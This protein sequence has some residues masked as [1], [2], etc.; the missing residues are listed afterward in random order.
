MLWI[1]SSQLLRSLGQA[2]D[3]GHQQIGVGLVM[4]TADAAAQMVQLRQA[5]LV[6]AAHHDRVRA[7]HVD[8][9]SR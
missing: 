2:F 9:G 1:A 5:E 7:R 6:G 3:V 4:R 8:A